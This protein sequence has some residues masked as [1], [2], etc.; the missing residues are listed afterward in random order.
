MKMTVHR[1]VIF[2]IMM[3][4]VGVEPTRVLSRRILSPLRLPFRHCP[5]YGVFY[6]RITFS[7][8]DLRKIPGQSHVKKRLQQ[9]SAAVIARGVC[10]GGVPTVPIDYPEA[11][12]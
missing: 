1:T 4:Q 9:L 7:D 10:D 11:I 12:S 5:I 6:T 8:A 3:G 2:A